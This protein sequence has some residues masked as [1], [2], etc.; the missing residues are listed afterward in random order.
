[1]K[2][3]IALNRSNIRDCSFRA[4]LFANLTYDINTMENIHLVKE[5]L[6]NFCS[7]PISKKIDKTSW[8]RSNYYIFS[9]YYIN[10]TH[11]N[12]EK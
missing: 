4:N 1:M 2:K 9:R 7:L 5:V 11:L 3:N 6:S 8:T 12:K 10:W